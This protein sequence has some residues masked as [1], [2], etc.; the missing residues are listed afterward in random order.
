MPIAPSVGQ[1][2]SVIH[3]NDPQTII[4]Y[5]AYV[6]VMEWSGAQSSGFGVTPITNF[7]ALGTGVSDDSAAINAAFLA[8]KGTGITLFFPAGTYLVTAVAINTQGVSIFV[9]SG[10]LFTGTFASSLVNGTVAGF[11]R[12]VFTTITTS[13][14][15]TGSGTNTLTFGTNAATGTQDGITV[16]VGDCFHLQGG[17]LGSC[18]ITAADIGPWVFTALGGASAKV[19]LTRPT[20]WLTG[21]TIPT[22]YTIKVGPEG[23]LFA[24]SDWKAF[25]VPGKVVGTDDPKFYPGRV[26]QP[27]T[28][29]AGTVTISNVPVLSATKSDCRAYATTVNTGTNTVGYMP[30]AAPTA[31]Y[32][33]AG[34]FVLDAVVANMTKNAS[35]VSVLNATI[36]NW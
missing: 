20:W 31:G 5:P 24:G 6:S 36:I 28:L 30:I 32:Q 12:G 22:A 25:A 10:A 35:D 23:T 14:T 16:A 27:V 33:G 3:S 26:V 2:A 19:V 18:A 34:S 9:G 11:V 15:Y 29:T 1:N 13:T 7:A 21:S 17:T 4:D 8:L